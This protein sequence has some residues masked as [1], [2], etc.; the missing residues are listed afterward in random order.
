MTWALEQRAIKDATARHVLLCLANY[1]DKD[2]KNAFPSVASLGEDTG[3][4]ERTIRYKLDDLLAAGL[5]RLGNQAIAAAYIGR[6][7]RRPTVYDLVMYRGASA[8]P[9]DA[10]GANDDATGCKSQQNGVQMT[11]ERGAAAAPNPS[12]IR[13]SSVSN[14]KEQG[15]GAPHAAK[16]VKFDPL[17]A[18]PANVS[19]EAWAD[20]CQHRRE[21]RKPLTAASCRHQAKQLEAH[22]NPDHVLNLSIANG[23]TGLFPE[24]VHAISQHPRAAGRPSAVDQVRAA[25]EARAAAE[26]APGAAGQPVA[27]NDRDVRAPLDG[28]F[29]RVG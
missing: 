14:P 1:A 12:V 10:R 17:T 3:L 20:W 19:P 27:E 21:I 8:A 25:I 22:P 15:A 5:I 23:W 26:A 6:H 13:H 4:S 9:G 18:C 24:K 28:E 16:A 11:T 29:R 7:D 2:G